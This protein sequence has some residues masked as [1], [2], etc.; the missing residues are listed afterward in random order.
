MN[1]FRDGK[2]AESV[3]GSHWTQD[4][5]FYLWPMPQAQQMAYRIFAIPPQEEWE[6]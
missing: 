1:F 6:A 2:N 5:A 3:L 4:P